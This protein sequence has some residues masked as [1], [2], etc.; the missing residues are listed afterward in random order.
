MKIHQECFK[1]LKDFNKSA[2]FRKGTNNPGV[3]MWGFSLEK[4]DYTIPSN[5][6]MF[7]PF[8]VG[9]V[10]KQNGCMYQRTQEHLGSLMGGNTSIF[11]IQSILASSVLIPNF[12]KIHSDY[13]K[14][15]KSAKEKNNIG[16]NLPDVKYPNLLHFP[17][18]IHRMYH[19]TTDDKIKAEIDWM[20]RHF[21][22]TYFKLD[23]YNKDDIH[24][25]EKYIGNLI[26]YQRLITKPYKKPNMTVEIVDS[27]KNIIVN[28]YE[29]L[30]EH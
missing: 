16:P 13:Q 28:E 12:G 2:K 9:R 14:I 30:F 7:L 4:T 21:C 24:D 19:F 25:L 15:S 10:E 18:G 11:D 1:T 22:I 8:Y 5:S 26:G 27:K 6:K 20:L 23:T 17:E 29:H 3:Y